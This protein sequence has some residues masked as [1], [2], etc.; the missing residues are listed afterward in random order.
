M[1]EIILGNSVEV[2]TTLPDNYIDLTVTSP[3]YDNLRT[4]NNKIKDEVVYEDGFS[5]P[6]V[7]MARQRGVIFMYELVQDETNGDV[8]F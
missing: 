3:P 1:N 5:F 4:Y 7:E 2:M 8:V 6:F